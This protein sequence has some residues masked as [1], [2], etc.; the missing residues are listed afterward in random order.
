MSKARK[1]KR[2]KAIPYARSFKLPTKVAVLKAA[3]KEPSPDFQPSPSFH[4]LSKCASID[5][6]LAQYAEEGQTFED[7][8]NQ[9]PWFSKRK[10]K[11][12]KQKFVK[13]GGSVTEKYPDGAIYLLPI[14]PLD[15][16]IEKLAKF[17]ETYLH[18]PVK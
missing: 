12:M 6:W 15:A 3:G 7:F 4:P 17:A 16:D 14:G 5:D 11:Y 18:I 8:L 9:N 1:E 13:D 2:P 10:I